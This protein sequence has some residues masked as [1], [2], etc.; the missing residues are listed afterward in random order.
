MVNAATEIQSRL[1]AAAQARQ[2][3]LRDDELK[4]LDQA[5][6]ID[7]ANPFALNAR[8]AR[9][10]S[11]G[12]AEQAADLFAKAAEADSGQPVLWMNLA[13]AARA[14]KDID[15][16]RA[17]LDRALEA[18]RY[19][20]GALLRQAELEERCGRTR[21]AVLGWNAFIQVAT[22]SVDRPAALDE[23]I[24][25]GQAYLKGQTD[26][27]A[28]DLDREF[29]ADRAGDPD[30]RRFNA[31]MDVLLGKRTIYRN[32]CQGVNY[33]FLPADEFFDKRHFPWMAELEKQTD[34]IRAEVL[35]LMQSPGEE[36]RPYVRIEKGAP[37]S[38]WSTLD[39]SLDWGACFL[40][41]YGEPNRPVLDRC[42]ATAAALEALPQS[43]IP[44]KAPSAFFSVLQPG[45]HI[46]PHTGVT[47]VRAIIHLP[48]VVPKGCWF[49]V[50]GETREWVEGEAFAFDD[51]I[52]HEAM[53]PTKERRIVLIF[54]VWNPHLT[55]MEQEHLMR[56]YKLQEQESLAVQ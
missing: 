41:E 2:R 16:E 56:F 42:P 5:L 52:E 34:A 35:A 21:E 8:G 20:L 9:A 47:N 10:L 11:D 15:R 44:G 32:E 23:A 37:Q 12:E 50:G 13:N 7:P 49:R 36:L 38:K 29:G 33:P 24:A 48:L 22:A 55:A 45:A 19:H 28:G 18:D 25:R 4:L 51:T 43:R 6:A 27:F 17:A 39:H 14:M 54:D 40:W 31:C 1:T 53:N 26:A 3:G 30:L 46:P